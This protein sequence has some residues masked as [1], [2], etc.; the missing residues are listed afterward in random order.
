MHIHIRVHRWVLWWFY[1]GV[2]C[3]AVAVI[4]ILSRNLSRGQEEFILVIG[5]LFWVLGGLL[6]YACEGIRIEKS[7]PQTKSNEPAGVRE[8][9]EWHAASDFLLPGN[10]K[11]L[12]PPKH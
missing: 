9:Q 8:Q 2:V 5:V 7:S 10:P 6:C 11:S 1:V 12:L 4:N 3:G